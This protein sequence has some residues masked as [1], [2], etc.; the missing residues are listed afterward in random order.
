MR[1]LW[2]IWPVP[3]GSTA[4]EAT[5]AARTRASQSEVSSSGV[6]MTV[7]ESRATEA[8]CVPSA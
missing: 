5:G 1:W 8:F 3:I 4:N 2:L 6:R 7:G